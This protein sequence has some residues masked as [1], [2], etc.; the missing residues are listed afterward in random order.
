MREKE[1]ECVGEREK[2]FIYVRKRECVRE[3]EIEKEWESDW[4]RKCEGKREHMCKW[5]R[6]REKEWERVRDYICAKESASVWVR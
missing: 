4:L 2:G 3:I 1:R 6:V 5:V